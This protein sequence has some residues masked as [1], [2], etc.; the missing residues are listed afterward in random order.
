[1]LYLLVFFAGALQVAM[2]SFN[3][4]LQGHVG[5]LGTSLTTHVTGGVLLI[6]YL[7]LIRR[8]KPRLGPMPWG[9]YS[10]GL[11]G[12]VLVAG[13]SLCV[14]TIGPAL[15]TCLNVSG[16]LILSILMDHNGWMGVRRIPFDPRRVPCLVVILAG[17]LAV[18]LGLRGAT[19]LDMTGRMA[20]LCVLLAFALGCL[21]VYSKAVN[22]RATCHLGAASGTLVNY[23]VASLLSA[24][25]LAG[26]APARVPPEVFLQA[27]AWL[28]LGG[29][30]GVVALVINVISLRKINLFQSTTLLLVGQL[31]GSTLLDGVLFHAMSPA[32]L[33]GMVLVGI[34][35]IWDKKRSL[36]PAP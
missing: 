30:F 25:L 26:L 11:W 27:P 4:L 31:A 22:Y 7:L 32:K 29:V 1:M 3:G 21:N 5:L 28:Y 36:P 9:L 16:Q 2:Q 8:E 33:L 34:G 10:A 20:S 6:A 17:V 24:L 15:T 18:N 23:V 35:M 19:A 14:G 12:L 13:S